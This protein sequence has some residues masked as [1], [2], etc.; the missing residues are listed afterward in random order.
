MAIRGENGFEIRCI[1]FLLCLVGL[2]AK[3]GQRVL[4][5]TLDST[6]KFMTS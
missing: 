4:E 5:S 1:G 6:F 2:I 3:A